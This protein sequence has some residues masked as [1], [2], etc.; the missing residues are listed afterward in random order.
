MGDLV[1]D[2]DST[3]VDVKVKPVAIAGVRLRPLM[4]ARDLRGSLCEIHR[5][6][7]ELAARPVQWD[8]INTRSHVLRGVHVHRLRTDYI[9]VVGG[10][11]TIG[12]AD[13]RRNRSSFRRG[14]TLKADG[15]VPQVLIIPPGVAH[16]IYAHDPVTYL[17]GLSAYYDGVDQAGCRFDDPA[18]EIDWPSP[19]PI[20][21]PRDADLPGFEILLREFEAAGGVPSRS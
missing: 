10:Q 19:D 18:L 9:V 2:V 12:L 8:F 21:L 15:E 13:L 3:D 7:W 5:D 4:P 6:S 16:G 11:A 17:Y 14:M 1:S 20:L